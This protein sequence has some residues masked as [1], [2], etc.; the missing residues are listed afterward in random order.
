MC[1]HEDITAINK[2]AESIKELATVT[3]KECKMLFL[4]EPFSQFE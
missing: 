2:E 1:I 4:K 3:L